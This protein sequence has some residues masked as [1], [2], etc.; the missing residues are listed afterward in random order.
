MT[1]KISQQEDFIK[2]NEEK[3][4]MLNDEMTKVIS[5]FLKGNDFYIQAEINFQTY[6]YM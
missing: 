4:A 6:I 3:I 2:E 1:S 5:Y